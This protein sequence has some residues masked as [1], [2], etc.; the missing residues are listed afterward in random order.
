[1]KSAE[2]LNDPKG[3][4][5]ADF[6]QIPVSM[7]FDVIVRTTFF[8]LWAMQHRWTLWW[9]APLGRK[10]K[11]RSSKA[12]YTSMKTKFHSNFVIFP[13]SRPV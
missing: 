4:W 5:G 1:M 2:V 10:C 12:T 7:I 3:I 9:Y 13:Y 8:V 11:P 6:D